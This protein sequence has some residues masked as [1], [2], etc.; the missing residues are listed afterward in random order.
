MSDNNVIF[1]FLPQKR[2]GAQSFESKALKKYTHSL[3]N[4]AVKKGS[5][6]KPKICS[7]CHKAAKL[8]GHHKDYS[9]PYDVQW[10]CRSCHTSIH[11]ELKSYLT[12]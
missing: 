8:F 7:N 3:V 6:D 9:L 1:G 10:M 4:Q 5:L 11:K 12:V 2:Q